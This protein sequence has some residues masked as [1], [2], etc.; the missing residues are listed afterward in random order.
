MKYW[1]DFVLTAVFL[2]NRLPIP[3]LNNKTPFEVLFKTKPTYSNL[4]IFGCLAFATTLIHNM[5]K[6]DPRGRRCVFLGYPFGIKG[7]KLLDLETKKIFIS[8]NVIFYENVFP[9]KNHKNQNHTDDSNFTHKL[10][11]PTQL[12]YPEPSDINLDYL[13]ISDPQLQIE[14]EQESSQNIE[15]S[16]NNQHHDEPEPS[17]ELPNSPCIPRR[18]DRNKRTPAY[19]QDFI[20]QRHPHSLI[21]KRQT[22]RNVL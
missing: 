14:P 15:H 4:R 21:L 6:F 7:Y 2:I 19:L 18:S 22:G 13:A 8:R 5:H 20:C 16:G 1:N 12:A 17:S 9:Y 10:P 11:S 3:V